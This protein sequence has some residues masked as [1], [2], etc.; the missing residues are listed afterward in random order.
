MQ[1]FIDAHPQHQGARLGNT[2]RYIF[3][4][5]LGYA[6]AYFQYNLRNFC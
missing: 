5:M 4:S 2:L 6:K 3:T 1:F